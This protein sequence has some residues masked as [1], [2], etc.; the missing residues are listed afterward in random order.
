MKRD[1][2]KKLAA[3]KRFISGIYNYCDRWCDRCLQTSR[4]LNFSISEEEFS[5]PEARDIRNETFWKKLSGVLG[6]T[7]EL[8]KE[9]ARDW[10]IDLE[11]LDSKDDV[12][13]M[14]AKEVVKKN[15][16]DGLRKVTPSLSRDLQTHYEKFVERQRRMA[17]TEE[18]R[19]PQSYIG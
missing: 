12:E 1:R 4:C 7:L 9:S 15:F 8:L 5:D 10:G 18:E 6:E 3:D 14:K 17:K 16:E 2:L 19:E 13:N 11:T